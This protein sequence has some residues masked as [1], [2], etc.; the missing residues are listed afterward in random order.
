MV[1]KFKV[2]DR[3][4]MHGYGIGAIVREIDPAY[5]LPYLI[6]F[7]SDVPF[8]HDGNAISRVKIKSC[9]GYWCA[10]N[11]LYKV[12]DDAT[13]VRTVTRREIVPGTYGVVSVSLPCG[14]PRVDVGGALNA[15]QLREA[16]HLFNQ[17]AEVIEENAK[18]E[19]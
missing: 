19:A 13:V 15:E 10:E 3:V 16:A 8:G 1:N 2:G 12:S 5:C 9:R 17:I 7:E 4:R 6:E 14:L 11:E 18:A